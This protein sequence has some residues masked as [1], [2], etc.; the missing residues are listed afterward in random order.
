M[1]VLWVFTTATVKQAA[2]THWAVIPVHVKVVILVMVS[3]AKIS[4]SVKLIMVV[5][6]S[7]QFA[8]TEKEGEIAVA[9][10]VSVEMAFSALII[11]NVLD[12]VSATGMPPA[13][14]TLVP[15][16]VH[17]MVATKAMEIIFV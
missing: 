11:M 9:S 14:T 6:M 5:A 3:N 15:M 2:L 1:N 8:P 12:Q 16:C 4:M 13:P 17:A 10:R 7:M